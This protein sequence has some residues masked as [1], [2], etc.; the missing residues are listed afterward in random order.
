MEATRRKPA[1][2]GRSG[3]HCQC[4]LTCEP[5]V[6]CGTP[7]IER[8]CLLCHRCCSACPPLCVCACGCRWWCSVP[9]GL[10][11]GG[12]WSWLRWAG[13]RVASPRLASCLVALR[14]AE[15]PP[16]TRLDWPPRRRP[17]RLSV[18]A[19][20]PPRHGDQTHSG[21]PL[22]SR[23]LARNDT[24][25]RGMRL[26]HCSIGQEDL[27]LEHSNT[28]LD[29]KG[30]SRVAACPLSSCSLP[31]AGSDESPA[32]TEPKSEMREKRKEEEHQG[33]G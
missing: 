13:R 27:L 20:P 19:A 11:V 17:H 7:V 23:P 6:G 16:P 25:A 4:A 9:V 33:C 15:P 24:C 8:P 26:R 1:Q 21:M 12:G 18:S 2:A 32:P 30:G 3:D 29:E 31:L 10:R 22:A 14:R 5:V 28:R